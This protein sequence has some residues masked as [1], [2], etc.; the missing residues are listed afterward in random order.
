MDVLPPLS[1]TVTMA[2]Y[3]PSGMGYTFTKSCPGS[4]PVDSLFILAV[5]DVL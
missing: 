5:H 4:V 1:V 2:V 3:S